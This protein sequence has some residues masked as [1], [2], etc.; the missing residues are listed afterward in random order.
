MSEIRPMRPDDL[1]EVAELYRFVD[2][3]D[4]RIP[5]SEVPGWLHRTLFAQPWF[6]G[7]I[8]SLVYIDD[9]GAIMGFIGSHARRMRF[10]GEPIRMTAAGPLIAH[11]QVRS[12]AVGA[13]LWRRLLAGPQQ[14]T[15][16]DGASD[17]M[18]QIFEMIGGQLMHPSSIAWARI[19]RPWSYIGNRVLSRTAWTR[20]RVKPW[21]HRPLA[22]LDVPTV[23]A[24]GRLRAPAAAASR[25]EPL[26]PELLIEHLPEIS[27]S[28][29]LVPDYD[30]PFLRWLF[31]ELENNKTWGTPHR[32]LV[33][34]HDGRVLGWYVYFVLER[35]G[36]QVI[37]LVARP[38]HEGTVLANLLSH[39][40]EHGAAAVQGRVEARILASLAHCGALFRFSPRSLVHSRDPA[41]IGSITS[42]SALLTRL[43]GEWWMAT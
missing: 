29:R 20:H 2:R 36:C 33:R 35:E 11:P 38:R 28:L 26:T 19:L 6:D 12:Q 32:R 34:A 17:E 37:H 1:P 8:P 10:D 21:A 3:S 43:E 39:A 18:R 9:A 40:Y 13:R 41:L 25:D 24:A 42:G 31:A 16:T 15:I 30:L 5:G 14:L 7:E 22:A 23:R 4:W 27:R